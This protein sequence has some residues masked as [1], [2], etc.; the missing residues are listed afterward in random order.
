ML[1]CCLIMIVNM[2]AQVYIGGSLGLSGVK[3]QGGDPAMTY[4]IIPEIGYV[5]DE[6]WSFGLTLG[7]KKG[8]CLIGSGSYGQNVESKVYGVQPYVRYDLYCNNSFHFFVDGLF[9][10]EKVVNEGTNYNCGLS[11]GILF[12]PLDRIGV[13][14]HMGFLGFEMYR[15]R[16]GEN[17]GAIGGL[18][19]NGEIL[20]IGVLCFF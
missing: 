17:L 16:K 18:E 4:K 11:P 10:Y 6:K 13:V 1:L 3:F 15:N 2:K 8:A 5:F 14:A 9:T 20:S 7:Y 12:T 19:L